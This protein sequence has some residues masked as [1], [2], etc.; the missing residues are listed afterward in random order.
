MRFFGV[1]PTDLTSRPSAQR[2][3]G[4]YQR[5]PKKL[6]KQICSQPPASSVLPRRFCTQSQEE[7]NFPFLYTLHGPL[8]KHEILQKKVPKK[9][10]PTSQRAH[11]QEKGGEKKPTKE[12]GEADLLPSDQPLPH[13]LVGP[14]AEFDDG[15]PLP[16]MVLILP[17]KGL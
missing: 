16:R 13:L 8:G 5:S 10:H 6:A 2:V 9:V 1:A 14:V 3:K 11:R 12:V 15:E 17:D 7:Q 4:E